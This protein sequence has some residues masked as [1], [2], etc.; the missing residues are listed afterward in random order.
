MDRSIQKTGGL[1]ERVEEALRAEIAGLSVGDK[2]PPE[3][4]MAESFGVSIVKVREAL[5]LLDREGLVQRNHGRGTFVC[6]PPVREWV[7]V[8]LR[9]DLANP[10][11]SFYERHVFQ[12]LRQ[13]LNAAGIPSRGYVGFG[14]PS[15]HGGFDCPEFFQDLKAGRVRHVVPVGGDLSSE[16]S[17]DLEQSGIGLSSQNPEEG[18]ARQLE[19][20]K[21]GTRYLISQGRRRLAMLAWL[22]NHEGGGGWQ[23]TGHT[24]IFKEELSAAGLRLF[25]PWVQGSLHP[26]LGGAGWEEFRDIWRS[27]KDRPDGLLICND[28][29]AGDAAVAMADIGVRVPDELLVVTHDNRGSGRWYPF[30]VARLEVDPGADAAGLAH[31]TFRALGVAENAADV[32]AASSC[33]LIPVEDKRTANNELETIL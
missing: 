12:S 5:T 17:R 20:V 19:I 2:L 6:Q 22:G 14:D 23:W 9:H 10:S 32:P 7:A 13:R 16:L 15:V 31:A 27:G 1:T 28:T 21:T 30:P 25:E 4:E 3:R 33:R 8:L 11:L 26:N 29:L 24:E 18:V